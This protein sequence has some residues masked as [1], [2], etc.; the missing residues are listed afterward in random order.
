MTEQQAPVAAAPCWRGW[1]RSGLWSLLVVLLVLA[2][3]YQS[4][5]RYLAP[6][7]ARYEQQI[8]VELS[9]LLK[10]QVQFGHISASWRGWSPVLYA[11]QVVVGEGDTRVELEEL[12]FAP[13]ML[14]SLF[15]LSWYV[16]ELSVR[17]LQLELAQE[18]DGSWQ[19][20]RQTL[21][22]SADAPS[23]EFSLQPL[24]QVSKFSLLDGRLRVRPH[25]GEAFEFA[26]F[27]LTLDQQHGQRIQASVELPDKQLL[28]LVATN[29]TGV[30]RWAGTG[31]AL[32]VQLPDT[33]WAQWLPAT[34]PDFTLERL[35]LAGQFWLQVRNGQLVEA[36]A[37]IASGAL[38]AGFLGQSASLQLGQIHANYVADQQQRQLW[39]D[40]LQLGFDADAKLYDWPLVVNQQQFA[41]DGL[42]VIQ[43]QAQQLDL[44][45]IF[46]QLQKF[47]P[48]ALAQEVLTS[49]N[50]KGQLR[51]TSLRWQQAAEWQQRLAFDT[52]L[53]NVEY[54]RWKA[55]PGA[56]GING[57]IFGGL[58]GGE[59]HLD[60][61]GFSLFLAKFFSTA[62]DYQRAK[63]RLTWELDEEGFRLRS[64][65]L[66][67][68]G[69]EGDIAGDFDIQLYF[70]D[71][72]LENY[73]D[74]R[75]G[76][77][78]GDASYAERYLPLVLQSEF[79]QLDDWLRSA[80][81]SGAIHEGY[82]QYQGS[83]ASG[84]PPEATSISLFFDVEQA[85]L[86]YQP[87]WPEL[88]KAKALVFV[89]DWG[90]Q[91]ELEQ[92]Q[93]LDS[94]ISAA[95]AE[96]L[97]APDNGETGLLVQAQ[98][99]SSVADGLYLLQNT[100]LAE[101]A[102]EFAGWTGRGK[103]P[104]SFSLEVPFSNKQPQVRFD[105]Q[106]ADAD[107]HLGDS[108]IVLEK[109]D[110]KLSYD[111]QTGLSGAA[112]GKFLQQG[113]RLEAAPKQMG[114]SWINQIM[115]NGNMEVRR[116]NAWLAPELK[117]PLSGELAYQLLL[118]IDGADSQLVVESDLLGVQVDLPPPFAKSK[119]H[120]LPASWRMSLAG[121]ERH[122]H[123][124][125]GQLLDFIA[126]HDLHNDSLRAA[127]TIGGSKARLPVSSGLHVSGRL[128]ELDVES[129][130]SSLQSLGGT[131]NG[132]SSQLLSEVKFAVDRLTLDT[133]VF[134]GV[135]LGFKRRQQQ[136]QLDVSSD[137]LVGSLS[138]EPGDELMLLAID[139]LHLPVAEQQSPVD[140]ASDEAPAQ[141]VAELPWPQLPQ[142]RLEINRLYQG[143]QLLG[144]V[145]LELR[146]RKNLTS[147]E[148]LD[149]QLRG[150][151]LKGVVDWQQDKGRSGFSGQVSGQDVGKVLEAWGYTPTLSSERFSLDTRLGWPGQPQQVALL[152]LDGEV[153]LSFRNGQLHEVDTGA[154]ALRVF[155]L[156]NFNSIGRRLRL[157]FSDLLGKGL[158]YD[159]LRGKLVFE[160]GLI[161]SVEPLV[162]KGVSSELNLAG[163]LDLN[164]NLVNARL[165]VS[166]PV[167]NN[168][169][170][171]AVLVG[172]PAVGGALFLVDRFAGNK[173][174]RF[175]S[176]SYYIS[177]DVQ[178]PEFT[179]LERA[180]ENK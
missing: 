54:S 164:A 30:S 74:L 101:Q 142:L 134:S 34:N 132:S 53:V 126:A 14:R 99:A 96:V 103:V 162:F 83:I 175:A 51:N 92:G 166:I 68:K 136:W 165:D 8:E 110:G 105:L 137:N 44:A 10:H 42:G 160:H 49:L 29:V 55:L 12:R 81:K 114:N 50:P 84:T 147:L 104:A 98:L 174:N 152:K 129:W 115:V 138:S 150:L 130:F 33:N 112:S 43:M 135:E 124:G 93:V 4:L 62:W 163:K 109:I 97:Y 128:Q 158:S 156:L 94:Q 151:T 37:R 122:L 28:Q 161:Y 155:G 23:G 157:D 60:S 89:H 88:T 31:F 63:A 100:P 146:Q 171:A 159:R 76:M 64:P 87:G 40:H 21:G 108:G 154:K 56:T 25:V 73:M 45:P 38:Q 17:G 80:I 143:D 67:V 86:A 78:N 6:Q 3:L 121:R 117:L 91:V 5:G 119:Q 52:N 41:A 120:R 9:R 178:K 82:F 141:T 145:Q 118:N 75:V 15:G 144:R 65:Y 58:G 36:Q 57:R 48:N 95:H 170:L 180:D 59:L 69:A 1:L 106:L 35:Q 113:F 123:F 131:D 27:N 47:I 140:A 22:S 177:G 79:S 167:S 61:D 133:A 179:L 148:E 70:N 46:A 7:L 20:L 13:D 149:V 173:I 176:V 127:L 72:E 107:L 18:A 26:N 39:F 102:S 71:D 116:L 19:I 24:A 111:S 11:T 32:Y 125:Y 172:A 168:L 16:G 153:Q 169:P 2:A 90:V 85:R 66:Q 139:R 77:R